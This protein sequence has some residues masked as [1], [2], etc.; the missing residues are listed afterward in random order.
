MAIQV[1]DEQM[2]QYRGVELARY[3]VDGTLAE[4]LVWVGGEYRRVWPPSRDFVDDF[5]APG[6]HERWTLMEGSYTPPGLS[7]LVAGPASAP[8]FEVTI[9]LPGTPQPSF[10]VAVMSMTTGEGVMLSGT[11]GHYSFMDPA[12]QY[13][14]WGL[15]SGDYAWSTVALRRTAGVWTVHAD[16]HPALGIDNLDPNRDPEN[17]VPIDAADP[18]PGQDFPLIIGGWEAVGGGDTVVTSVTYT[19]L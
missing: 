11:E 5:T 2:Q 9:G 16:G 13:I 12:Q 15:P 6:L 3:G 7:G 14:S 19:E 1:W 8:D 17:P 18:F 4:A 10:M